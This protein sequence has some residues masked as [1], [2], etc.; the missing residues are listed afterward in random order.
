MEE[1][2]ELFDDLSAEIEAVHEQMAALR[3]GASD[4]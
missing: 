3:F 1:V 2:R 4:V